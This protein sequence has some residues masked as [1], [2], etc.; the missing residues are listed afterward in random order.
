MPTYINAENLIEQIRSLCVDENMYGDDNCTFVD[1]ANVEE[2]IFN[3]PVADVQ[4]V[5]HG[6]WEIYYIF[7]YEVAVCSNC[8]KDFVQDTT[9]DLID[10]E[11]WNYCPNC[12]AKMDEEK[13]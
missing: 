13:K 4:E 5:K 7:D 11:A 10:F 1:F 9:I 6:K 3:A 12:G 2:I 8:H